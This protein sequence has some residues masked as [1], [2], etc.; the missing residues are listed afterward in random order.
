MKCYGAPFARSPLW[1]VHRHRP[2]RE[3]NWHSL[4]FGFYGVDV[5]VDADGRRSMVDG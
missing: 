2:L 4:G 1:G 5:D 3:F